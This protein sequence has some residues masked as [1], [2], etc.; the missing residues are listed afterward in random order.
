MGTIILYTYLIGYILFYI[1][2]QLNYMFSWHKGIELDDAFESIFFGLF[3]SSFWPLFIIAFPVG[4]LLA[5][6][7]DVHHKHK[8]K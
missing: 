3:L 7:E 2:F 5:W 4:K 8:Y 6:M 1:F